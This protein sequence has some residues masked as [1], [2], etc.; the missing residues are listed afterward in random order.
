M[1]ICI[2]KQNIFE[3]FQIHLLLT[4]TTNKL[5]SISLENYFNS[6]LYKSIIFK[7]YLYSWNFGKCKLILKILLF[8]LNLQFA[9]LENIYRRLQTYIRVFV[10]SE[11]I[12]H[13]DFKNT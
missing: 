3:E 5:Q 7:I 2:Y 13:Q 6:V 12:F 4:R 11:Y 9:I 1:S 10:I 8:I